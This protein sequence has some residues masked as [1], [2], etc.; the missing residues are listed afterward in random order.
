[1]GWS[2]PI[3]KAITALRALDALVMVIIG[4]S[5]GR[6]DVRNRWAVWHR[7]PAGFREVEYGSRKDHAREA[8]ISGYIK[9][10]HG[11]D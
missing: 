1:M 4:C 8:Q 2:V 11:C 7:M 10:A 3:L 5:C 9:N 6:W